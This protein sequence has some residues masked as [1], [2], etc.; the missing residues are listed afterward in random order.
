M[1]LIKIN[2]VLLILAFF[3]PFTATMCSRSQMQNPG[4]T[5]EASKIKTIIHQPESTNYLTYLLYPTEYSANG[6]AFTY[7]S[8]EKAIQ[9]SFEFDLFQLVPL[10]FICSIFGLIFSFYKKRRLVFYL[11]LLN[12]TC[13]LVLVAVGL[14]L[15]TLANL[16]AGLL[17]GFWLAILLSGVDVFLT[18]KGAYN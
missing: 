10:A 4:K 16:F 15:D 7:R 5:T 12:L 18:K 13:F 3:M 14:V 8:F 1:K 9:G 17:W 11:S 6:F 2:K